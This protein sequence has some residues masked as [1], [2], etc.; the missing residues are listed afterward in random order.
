[1][2][3]RTSIPPPP[4]KLPVFTSRVPT[5]CLESKPTPQTVYLAG[6]PINLSTL[7]RT[8]KA[9]HSYL[10]R[11][12][13]GERQPRYRHGQKIASALGMSFEAFATHIMARW[14]AKHPQK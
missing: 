6:V 11:I 14:E 8:M 3:R 2:S 9:D 7:A 4:P 10:S 5:M 13:S 1:M 12:L